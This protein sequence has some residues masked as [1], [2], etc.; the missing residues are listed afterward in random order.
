[1]AEQQR[2]N[3]KDDSDTRPQKMIVLE[4]SF[5]NGTI[6]EKG[7]VVDV[8]LGREYNSKFHANLTPYTHEAKKRVDEELKAAEAGESTEL[9]GQVNTADKTRA[10]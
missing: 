1:M 5:I 7:A 8:V 3:V 9:P 2:P 10:A 4:K 6:H